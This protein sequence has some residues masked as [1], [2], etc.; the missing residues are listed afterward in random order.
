[1]PVNFWLR[2]WL[3]KTVKAVV[4][5]YIYSILVYSTAS[6]QQ[7]QKESLVLTCILII[8][9]FN[10]L[11]KDLQVFDVNWNTTSGV[12]VQSPLIDSLVTRLSFLFDK[13]FEAI[14]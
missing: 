12:I 11:L 2:T 4:Y 6:T 9:C 10:W 7:Q 3:L 1:M 8:H 14:K 13:L 5:M